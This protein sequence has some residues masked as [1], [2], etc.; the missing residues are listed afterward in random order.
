M[1]EIHNWF[2]TF[3]SSILAGIAISIGGCVLLSVDNRVIGAFMFTVGLYTICVH[4]LSLFTGKIGSIVTNSS[5]L[6][7]GRELLVIWVGNLTGTFLAAFFMDMAGMSGLSQRASQMCIVKINNSLWHLF[8]LGIFCGFL[9]FVAVDGYKSTKN[10]IILFIG[11]GTFI[12]CGFEHCVADM[13]YFSISHTW[14]LRTF[15]CVAAIT[16]GN[17]VG[18]ILIPLS[19]KLQHKNEA[20][21]RS[22]LNLTGK[23]G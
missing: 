10:P 1:K 8:L 6:L 23:A 5:P 11:V 3:F 22:H 2:Y 17:S 9:V 14:S 19:K 16:L 20:D 7:Y 21:S 4:E 12:L 13:F 18:G 15:L